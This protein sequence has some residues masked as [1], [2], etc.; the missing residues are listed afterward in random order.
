MET[1]ETEFREIPLMLISNCFRYTVKSIVYTYLTLY[2]QQSLLLVGISGRNPYSYQLPPQHILLDTKKI[3]I[4]WLYNKVRFLDKNWLTARLRIHVFF[5][6]VS[7]YLNHSTFKFKRLFVFPVLKM[8]FRKKNN[9]HT[10]WNWTKKLIISY[11]KHAFNVFVIRI[12]IWIAYISVN[13][14][15]HIYHGHRNQVHIDSELI[16]TQMLFLIAS[17][18]WCV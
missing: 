16:S 7:S 10:I 9:E 2:I 12:Q 6:F 3:L 14:S 18:T 5:L 15:F 17:H 8:P 11:C 13:D 4:A 1:F